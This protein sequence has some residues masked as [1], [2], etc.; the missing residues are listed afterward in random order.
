MMRDTDHDRVPD[1]VL[2]RYVLDEVS[3]REKADIARRLREDAELRARLAEIERSDAEIRATDFV[4]SLAGRVKARA[5]HHAADPGRAVP[6][7][8]R[9]PTRVL[10]CA[11]PLAVGVTAMLVVIASRSAGVRPGAFEDR[12]KGLQPSLSVF[13]QTPDGSERLSDRATARPGDVIRLAYQAAG[14]RY[15]VILSLDGSGVVTMHLPATGA[16]A[17]RLRPGDRV[18]VDQAYEFDAAPRWECF[19]LVTAQTPFDVSTVVEAARHEAARH[20]AK[21]PSALALPPGFAQAR[22]LVTKEQAP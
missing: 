6:S 12:I 10:R 5:G 4:A 1:I 18:L 2:E 13:R 22:F 16:A 3:S 21:P 14:Q 8:R 7:T 17:V 11:L 20:P 19:Y 9:V 15:G